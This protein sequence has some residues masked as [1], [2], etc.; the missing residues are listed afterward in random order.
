[1]D[2]LE[3]VTQPY[4][5]GSHTA[6]AEL[7]GRAAPTAE[8]EAELWMGA[9]PSAP[10]RVERSGVRTTLDAVIAADPA[11]ELGAEVVARF[12]GRLPFLLKVLA[13]RKSL[14]IQV[15]PSREQAEAGYRAETE[16]GLAPGDKSRNYVDDWPKPEILCALTRFEVL[17]GMRTAADAAALLRTLEVGELA[18]IAAELAGAELAGAEQASAELAD[19][20]QASA[21]LAD[22]ELAGTGAPAAL[23][24]ALAAILTWPAEGRGS[25]IAAVVAACERIAARGGA[26]AATCAATVRIAGDH[27]GDLGI[28]ASLLLRYAVLRPG[29][30]VFLSAGALHSYLRGTGVELLAN[31]D[32]VV[33]AGLTPKHIDVP[34][35]LKLIDPA[36]DVPL[37]GP[38]PIGGGVSVYDS[39]AQEFHLYRAELGVG[40]VALPAAGGPRIVLCTEGAGVLNAR[41]GTLKVTRGESCYLSAADTAV[42]ASGPA[43]LFIA[44]VGIGVC[45]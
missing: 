17:A 38:R 31:S 23:T 35:L 45:R 33:R 8:P 25:L 1:V 18:P 36:A 4:A 22:T 15:H 24:R 43:V 34:E 20:E 10:S 41:A 32:N 27:P 29:Q 40:E 19:T 12:G 14:S 42:T 30:A 13:A 7:Q 5:W 16:R 28:V 9:H 37:I 2:L 11:G 6:I 39:P 21:E 44:G 3:P 26:Y